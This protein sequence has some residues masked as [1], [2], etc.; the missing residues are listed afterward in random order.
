MNIN[1]KKSMKLVVLLITSLLIGF[2]SA[3]SYT[4]LFMY[5]T[6][7][8][9]GTAG[10]KFTNGANTTTISTSG[11]TPA[12]TE[13]TFDN[14]AAIEPGEIRTYEQVVNITNG[15]GSTK[16]LNVSLYSLTGNLSA[17]FDY[18]NITVIDGTGAALGSNITILGSGSNTTSTGSL[19]MTANEVWSV[20]W[21]IKARSDAN[22]GESIS[23]TLMVR[24]E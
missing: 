18:L 17:N 4:E 22:N 24:A 15:S 9:I 2:A 11:I 20:R 3:A 14:I 10:V 21:D 5:G 7:I 1:Y 13:V 8:T 12:A 19:T 23:V 16:A 6:P